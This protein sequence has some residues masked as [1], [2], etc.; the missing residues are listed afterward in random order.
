LIEKFIEK[1]EKTQFEK[2]I[3]DITNPTWKQ[4]RMKP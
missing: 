2:M 1:L 4:E 3:D